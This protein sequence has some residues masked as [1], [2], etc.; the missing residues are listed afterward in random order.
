MD[1]DANLG[2]F[3]LLLYSLF[4]EVMFLG[5]FLDDNGGKQPKYHISLVISQS[6]CPFQHNPK[7]ITRK[8]DIDPVLQVRMGKGII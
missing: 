7:D 3:S 4:S 1:S 6:V 8:V 2:Y 5:L